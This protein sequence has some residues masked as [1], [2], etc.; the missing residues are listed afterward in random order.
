MTIGLST[1]TYPWAFGIPDQPK[2]KR[3]MTHGD[4]IREAAR[5]GVSV[6]QLADN[7]PL[8]VSRLEAV[9]ASAAAA[10]VTVELGVRG[11]DPRLLADSIALCERVGAR[12]LRT[13]PDIAMP[14]GDRSHCAAAAG[15]VAAGATIAAGTGTADAI[16]ADLS[17]LVPALD[18]AGVTLCVENYEG[19]P[20]AALARAIELIGSQRVRVC[21]DSLNSIGRSEGYD[22][23]VALLGPLTSNLHVKDY[24]IRRV[25]H[26]L[27]FLVEGRS[28]G[29]GDLPLDDLLSRVPDAVSAIVELWTPWQGSLDATVELEA[30]WAEQSVAA[31][32][33]AVDRRKVSS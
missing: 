18:A 9:G 29:D 15:T 2:P 32:R 7:A 27:G 16:A 5:L 22:E 4:L 25:D 31:L 11:T 30:R 33:G 20:V 8:V 14:V 3:P 6:V 26:R 23:V 21:L 1:Y 28:A 12:V 13:V 19:C 17:T 10:G 24:S